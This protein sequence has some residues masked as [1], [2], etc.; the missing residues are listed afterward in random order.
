MDL[1]PCFQVSLR[2]ADLRLKR[3]CIDIHELKRKYINIHELRVDDST[4]PPEI[5]RINQ[6]LLVGT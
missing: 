5:K 1:P 4:R 6:H 2:Y 3:K